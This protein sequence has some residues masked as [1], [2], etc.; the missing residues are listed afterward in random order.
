MTKSNF[1]ESQIVVIKQQFNSI[2]KDR[3]GYITESEF[4]ET[5]KSLNLKPEEYDCQGFFTK[6]DKNKDGKITFSEFLNAYH[7]LG[8]GNN[9]VVTGQSG[10]K[11]QKEIDAIFNAFDLDGNG[12]ITEQELGKVLAK[13]GDAPS[14][15]EIKKMMKAAD[16]NG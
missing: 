8:L 14:R 2:D 1:S 11:S 4:L 3:D 13:Q 15:E 7:D 10:Q 16:L 12:Y 5:L 6:A 9:H